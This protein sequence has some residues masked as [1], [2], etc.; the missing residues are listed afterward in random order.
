MLMRSELK[1]AAEAILFV[2]ADRME[3]RELARLLEL[4]PPVL[5]ELMEELMHDYSSQQRGIQ[6]LQMDDQYIL[7]TNP[8]YAEWI[9]RMIKPTHRR[10]SSAAME[11]LAIIAY[12]QPATKGEIEQIRGVNSER[13]IS[14]LLERGIICELGQR[15]S[16]GR[17]MLYGT[18]H[19]F[20]R[21]FGI[22]N[23]DQLPPLM[24]LA[25]PEESA[26]E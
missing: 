7:A 14:N 26:D 22:A 18:T 23:L 19:E 8:E 13:I 1:A 20:L 21:M 24:E 25:E 5:Q 2:H 12:R 17:P 4:D 10:L 9:T 15:P 11:T 3:A 6:L 16:P